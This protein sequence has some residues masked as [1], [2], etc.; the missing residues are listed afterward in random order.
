[1][2][3][4]LSAQQTD[5]YRQEKDGE[6]EIHVRLSQGAQHVPNGKDAPEA[7]EQP[8]DENAFW[9]RIEGRPTGPG[10]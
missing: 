7:K 9:H 1:L 4:W 2:R 8:D 5:A 3:P 6:V 10:F